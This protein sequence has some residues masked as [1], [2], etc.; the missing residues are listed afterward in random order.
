TVAP[1]EMVAIMGPSG[2]GKTT[3]LN[4]LSG[5]DD[6]DE[7]SVHIAGTDITRMSDNAKTDFRAREMG[8]VF[9]T[10]NLLPVLTA[11]ANVEWPLIGAGTRPSDAR[12]AAIAA[13]DRVG[14]ADRA[15]NRPAARSGGQR[16]R[17]TI[18]RALRNDP[19]I[20]WADAPTAALDSKTADDIME[21]LV[22]L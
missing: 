22:E 2:C 7:G 1:G 15:N 20:V 12:K 10:Y 18:A 5:L 19:S 8:F 13:L 9:Q 16:Q 11:A 14:R 3:L 6:F 4:C 21:L 17:L